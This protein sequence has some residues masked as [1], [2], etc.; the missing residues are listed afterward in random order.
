MIASHDS[1]AATAQPARRELP[2][3]R[4]IR[5]A[6][7]TLVCGFALAAGSALAQEKGEQE[8]PPPKQ[9]QPAAKEGQPPATE[10]QPS[11]KEEQANPK[12]NMEWLRK[13]L[14][15]EGKTLP[16]AD[17]K[18]TP[19]V[20]PGQ[21]RK[22]PPKTPAVTE[23]PK[24]PVTGAP[25]IRCDE[26]V[27]DF[28][29]VWADGPLK[30]AY[31]I[32]NEGDQDL[33]IEKVKPSCGCTLAGQFDKVI[34]PGGQGKIPISLKTNKLRAKFKKFVTVNSNDPVTPTLRMQLAGTI[35]HHVDVAPANL[36]F[37]HVMEDE[38]HD[39]TATITNNT[40]KPMEL[41]FQSEQTIGPFS[42]EL[43]EK[44]PGKVYE[45]KVHAKPPYQPKLNRATFSLKTNL[46]EQPKVDIPI[47]AYLT[48]RLELR[49]HQVVVNT[50]PA[51]EMKRLI[52]FT[53]N[54]AKPVKVL[55]IESDDPKIAAAYTE[56]T[57]GKN[58]EIT[59]TIP[60]GH[61]PS[62]TGTLVTVKTDDPQTPT[63]KIPVKGR[64]PRPD[65]YPAKKLVGKPAPK[66]TFTAMD[67]S[68]VSSDDLTGKVTVLDFYKT[69]CGF[70]KRQIP[71]ISQ[72]YQKKYADNPNVRF[73]AVAQD[74]LKDPN[75]AKPNPRARSKEEIAEIY[76][77]LG[78]FEHV[79][80]PKNFG[81][82]DFK[83]RGVPTLMLLGKDG[84]VEAVHIGMPRDHDLAATVETEIDLL[85]AGK[86]RADFP[87]I[88]KG[89]PAAGKTRAVKGQPGGKKV[90]PPPLRTAGNPKPAGK[91]TAPQADP[92]KSTPDNVP[93]AKESKP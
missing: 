89:R 50:A 2:F 8:Q 60:P 55:S 30:H 78:K 74:P 86:T 83:V 65:R 13:K 27:K 17:P 16:P 36:R 57:P 77:G 10:E 37:S 21:T 33:R 71:A 81:K 34:P 70:C 32:R 20:R 82:K 19:P 69:R 4:R 23:T 84:T 59:I 91:A 44:E 76:N 41:T 51:A 1:K 9:E 75:A 58:Y 26:P 88:V 31:I 54:S 52:R 93:P 66:A 38:E 53:N 90:V 24:G 11:A 5:I 46:K 6:T 61:M 25:G 62:P 18:A 22:I 79:F 49:P 56:R 43:V 3:Q 87:E 45:F 73:V 68:T 40:G 28:G 48:P 15:A 47:T 12:T 14:E 64:Q 42:V 80:D 39:A 29:E 85:L 35:K 72:L 7:L 67:D 92:A 63:L